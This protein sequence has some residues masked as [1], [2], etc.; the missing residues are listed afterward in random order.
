MRDKYVSFARA[1]YFR[2]ALKMAIY[3]MHGWN[4]WNLEDFS[5]GDKMVFRVIYFITFKHFFAYNSTTIVPNSKIPYFVFDMMLSKRLK[6]FVKVE[7]NR[8]SVSLTSNLFIQ[9]DI[10]IKRRLI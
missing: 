4:M 7:C 6:H 9:T 10:N 8:D 2:M 5:G 3:V 1:K